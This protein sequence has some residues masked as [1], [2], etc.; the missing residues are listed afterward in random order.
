M[1][2][3]KID[4]SNSNKSVDPKRKTIFIEKTFIQSKNKSGF[5]LIESLSSIAHKFF[6]LLFAFSQVMFDK[7]SILIAYFIQMVC[8]MQAE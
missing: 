4:Q 6:S 3:T 8:G 2:P 7:F 1:Y 5:K